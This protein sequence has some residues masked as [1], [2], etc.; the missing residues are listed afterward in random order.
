M[1]SRHDQHS[2]DSGVPELSSDSTGA[3]EWDGSFFWGGF[4]LNSRPNLDGKTVLEVGCG[5]GHRTLEAASCGASRVVGVDP[6][7]DAIAAARRNLANSLLQGTS[8]V[9]FFKGTIDTLPP[10][11]FDVV[12]SE[13]SLEHVMDVP[14]LLA[15]IRNRLKPN[16]KFYLGFGPLYH[17]PD[18]DHGWLRAVLP[19]RRLFLWPWGHLLLKDYAFRKLSELHNRTLNRTY[20]WPYLDLN[21]LSAAEYERAFRNSGLHVEYLFKN[22][23][24]T[25]KARL[26]GLA[27]RL[28]VLSKYFVMNMYVILV[29]RDPSPAQS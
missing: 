18:G 3:K 19:G 2:A 14:G 7:E 12:I 4:G 27:A 23:V 20:D 25:R 28:P 1:C 17:A 10:E 16:G 21:Q 8:R 26:F 13:S 15:G 11:K 9:N 22:H 29:P 5:E 24:R 6:L